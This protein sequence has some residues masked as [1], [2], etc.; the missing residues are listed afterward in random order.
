MAYL[1]LEALRKMLSVRLS[2]ESPEGM[3]LR[4]GGRLDHTDG[5]LPYISFPTS[6]SR[7]YIPAPT[8]RIKRGQGV[9]HTT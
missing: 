6:D 8:L 1:P 7:A 4:M 2:F 3:M 9:V 5:R